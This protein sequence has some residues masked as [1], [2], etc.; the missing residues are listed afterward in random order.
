M[1]LKSKNFIKS[2]LH[3]GAIIGVMI[4]LVS[5]CKEVEVES[6]PTQNREIKISSE[7]EKNIEK[8]INKSCIPELM[9]IDMAKRIYDD[10]K[11]GNIPSGLNFEKNS[12]LDRIRESEVTL[13]ECKLRA[14]TGYLIEKGVCP[15]Y[16]TSCP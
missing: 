1:I 16:A 8:I 10:A 13:S 4:L 2:R 12:L 7:D 6:H 3:H 5:G 14:R 11:N 9:S 15:I